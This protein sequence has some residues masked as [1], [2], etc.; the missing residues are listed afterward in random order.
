MAKRAKI[1]VELKLEYWGF[2]QNNSGGSFVN[3]DKLC[4]RV[5]IEAYSEE[6][7]CDKGENLGM[8]FNG[9]EDGSDCPC[10]GDRWYRPD[11][12]EIPKYFSSMNS[13]KADQIVEKYDAI[14]LPV[15]TG[16]KIYRDKGFAVSFNTIEAYA[17]YL[18]DNHGYSNPD[19][20]IYH[21]NGS[22]TEI[23]SN[24]FNKKENS[25]E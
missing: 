25:D 12:I 2:D 21:Y 14:K 23:N 15:K 13:E 22:V 18:A 19:A 3:D 4:H 9:C 16:H 17:Q 5:F 7:A 20:R 1:P 6:E 11:F 8:Y 10:C 24:R